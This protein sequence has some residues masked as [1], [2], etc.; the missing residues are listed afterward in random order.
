LLIN[1][2]SESIIY[3]II[4]FIWLPLSIGVLFRKRVFSDEPLLLRP[5]TP[6][7]FSILHVLA[8][9]AAVFLVGALGGGFIPDRSHI[10]AAALHPAFWLVDSTWRVVAIFIVLAFA[11]R[12][13]QGGIDGVGMKSGGAIGRGILIGLGSIA[14]TWPLVFVGDGI[15]VVVE[16]VLWHR[17][18]PQNS[19]LKAVRHHPS[20]QV[21]ALM[22]FSLCILAPLSEELFFR[23]LVQSYLVQVLAKL[24]SRFVGPRPAA[25]AGTKPLRVAISPAD[26][27]G[28]I[29]MSSLFFALAHGEPSAFVALFMLGLALGYVYER[30]G[31]LWTDM[32]MHS[33]FNGVSFFATLA[34]QSRR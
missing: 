17:I 34:L 25:G 23:G 30:T 2:H 24:R 7:K 31:N 3:G 16:K 10:S 33:V 18:A 12:V 5:R 15:S 19:L 4:I 11:A 26:R 8:V 32:T 9:I 21:L 20:P 29:F 27:W 22:A 14:V 28:G 1:H 6:N 13:C